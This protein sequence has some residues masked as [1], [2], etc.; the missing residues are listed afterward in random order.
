MANDN[1][2]DFLE[3]E[4]L[5]R[6]NRIYE[7]CDEVRE[8]VNAEQSGSSL[9]NYEEHVVLEFSELLMSDQVDPLLARSLIM[10]YVPLYVKN[11]IV[12]SYNST[13]K[14]RRLSNGK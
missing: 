14:I 4:E 2:L 7:E 12:N 1:N 13:M 8:E 6:M 11:Y 5:E 10:Q 3:K 9:K